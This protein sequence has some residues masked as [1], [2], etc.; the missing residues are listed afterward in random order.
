MFS[1]NFTMV[2][3]RCPLDSVAVFGRSLSKRQKVCRLRH[4]C[5]TRVKKRGN[6]A[7]NEEPCARISGILWCQFALAC[8]KGGVR[9]KHAQCSGERGAS[10]WRVSGAAD[11]KGAGDVCKR[12]MG[13]GV[14]VEKRDYIIECIIALLRCLPEGKLKTVLAFVENM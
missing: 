12:P 7:E 4:I 11:R 9:C 10:P 6:I 13:R 1:L 3:W 2:R 5:N 8:E 14:V